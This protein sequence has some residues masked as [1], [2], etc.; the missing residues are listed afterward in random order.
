MNVQSAYTNACQ[1]ELEALKP[2]N[3]H[4]FADGHGMQVQHFIDS[5]EVSAPLLCDDSQ[6]G[7]RSLGQ[8]I[9]AALEVTYAKVACNTNLGIILL[10]APIVQASLRYPQLPLRAGLAQVLNETTLEDAALTYAGIRLVSPAGM[11][12][13]NEH[14]ISQ[15]PQ[16]TLLEAMQ[17]ASAHDMVARQY[18]EGYAQLFSQALPLYK[19]FV[20]R[21][22]RP[23]WALT[24]VYLYW[25]S[26][27][28]DSHI[29]RKY[30]TAVALEV[31]QIA[32][33]HAQAFMALDNP[34]HYMATL[35]KW[36]QSLKQARLNPGTSADLTVITAMLAMLG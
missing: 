8:R 16:I 27:V 13:R 12:E 7:D 2:G 11:G 3:V 20:Q 23:A 24:A 28:P 1:A 5:A 21:W 32:S 33:Q 22:Q 19:T 4:I 17:L 15:Q 14:D 30:G 35:L 29:A 26:S 9:L 31:Q 25:L 36:D 6:Y 10:A 34:K 18:S